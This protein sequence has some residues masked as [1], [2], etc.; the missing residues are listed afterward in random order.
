MATVSMP[1]I[2]RTDSALKLL[3][4]SEAPEVGDAAEPA[5]TKVVAELV[6]VDE[7]ADVDEAA[8]DEAVVVGKL[9]GTSVGSRTVYMKASTITYWPSGAMEA[10]TVCEALSIKPDPHKTECG[11]LSAKLLGVGE[12]AALA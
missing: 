8:N 11:S 6:D 3:V 2:N 9:F 10:T 1:A 7:V 5:G 12:A 4:L